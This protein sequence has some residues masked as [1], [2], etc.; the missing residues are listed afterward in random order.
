MRC[1]RKV[2]RCHQMSE[3]SFFIRGVQLPLCARCTGIVL[4]FLLLGPLVSIF[5]PGN[6]YLSL[7]LILLMCLD[8]LLQLKG[9]LQSTNLRRVLSGLGF[10]YGCFSVLLH[11]IVKAIEIL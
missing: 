7:A 3:R 2:F 8:G 5:T 11:S 10:G 6:M 1:C 4:G 9:V